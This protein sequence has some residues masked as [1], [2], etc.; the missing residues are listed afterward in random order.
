MCIQFIARIVI[1]VDKD[2]FSEKRNSLV[3]VLCRKLSCIRLCGKGSIYMEHK[4]M[5]LA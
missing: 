3:T 2:F 1:L 5:Q 4:H